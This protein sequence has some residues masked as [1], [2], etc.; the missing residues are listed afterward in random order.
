M[1][2]RAMPT[3]CFS[4]PLSLNPF[5]PT[6]VYVCICTHVCSCVYAYAYMC[7]L[8][9]YRRICVHTHTHTHIYIYI[10]FFSP[11][12]MCLFCQPVLMYLHMHTR[13]LGCLGVYTYFRVCVY[14]FCMYVANEKLHHINVCMY[15]YTYVYRPLWSNRHGTS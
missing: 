1:I 14:V 7:Y 12:P 15:I 3:R 5:S 4:P 13:L 6:C 11:P 10:R 8:Y 9:T 2:V